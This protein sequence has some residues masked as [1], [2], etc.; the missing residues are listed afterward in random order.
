M[1]ESTTPGALALRLHETG[2]Q[3]LRGEVPPNT[4]VTDASRPEAFTVTG[5]TIEFTSL[6]ERNRL[7]AE[8]TFEEV[9]GCP[10][11]LFE[12][13]YRLWRQEIG[14]TDQASGRLLAHAAKELDIVAAGVGRI[15]D[16]KDVFTVLHLLEAAM[17][18]LDAL[19]LESLIDLCV[20]KHASTKND[21]AGGVFHSALESWFAIRPRSAIDLRSRVLSSL[22]EPTVNL[23]CN[24]VMALSKSDFAQAVALAKADAVDEVPLRAGVGA[25]TLGRL[26]REGT[27]DPALQAE[28]TV[29]LTQLI[30]YGAGETRQQAIGAATG[31]LHVSRLFDPLLKQLAATGDQLVLAGVAS[32]LFLHGSEMAQRDDLIEWLDFLTG[33]SPESRWG[34]SSLDR[35]LARLL[36]E[37]RFAPL[38][39]PV[40]TK[41]TARHGQRTAMDRTVSENFDGTCRKLASDA[42]AWSKLLTDWLL[43]DDRAHAANLAG[44]MSM[45]SHDEL[46]PHRLEKSRV[47]A[48]DRAGLLF[49]ARRLL[50]YIYDRRQVTALA[51]SALA[52]DGPRDRVFPT[53]RALLAD[54]LGYDYPGSTIEACKA[55][56]VDAPSETTAFLLS[57]ADSIEKSLEAVLGL[58]GRK[59]FRPPERLRREFARARAKQMNRAFE[60]ASEKSVWRQLATEIHIKAGRATFQYQNEAYGQT[61]RLGSITHSVEMPRREIF[62][63]VGNAI[64]LLGFRVAKRGEE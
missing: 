37:V 48:L 31:S 39:P 34:M 58:P 8:E 56:A 49:M 15:R 4:V 7:V 41:W 5:S 40:L 54:E 32:T 1:A 23:L 50:G 57:V 28:I 12:K 9:R 47:E 6:A 36:T 14:H 45:L 24:A 53:L 33:L 27:A 35:A 30:E 29:A 43:S 51:L 13:A 21:L 61:M 17:P 16:G 20:A 22:S 46:L 11:E 42:A 10:D 55:A 25:W 63:P 38:V 59:E 62:D 52:V 3:S 44:V 60:E 26:L 19:K 64:R 2:T 18:H